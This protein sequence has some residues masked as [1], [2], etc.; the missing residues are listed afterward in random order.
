[1]SIERAKWI[2]GMSLLLGCLI[3]ILAG[4]GIG[5]IMMAEKLKNTPGNQLPIRSVEVTIDPSHQERL[6]EQLR[7]FADNWAYAIRIASANP[8]GDRFLIQMWRE[9]IKVIATYPSDPGSLDIW[10]YYTNPSIPVPGRYFDEEIND[11][12]DFISEIPN[13]TFTVE[14]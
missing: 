13:S 7:K 3:G 11:L 1:M 9:D 12:K 4:L 6:F 5:K 8:S 14:K 2:A 10:F